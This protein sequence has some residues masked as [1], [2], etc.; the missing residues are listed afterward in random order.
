MGNLNHIKTTSEIILREILPKSFM[1][2]FTFT[3]SLMNSNFHNEI[4]ILMVVH[5]FTLQ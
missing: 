4:F 1:P 2:H 3:Y 5:N